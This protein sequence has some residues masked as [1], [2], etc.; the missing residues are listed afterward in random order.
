M[1]RLE[2]LTRMLE[3][4]PDDVFVNFGL[5]MEQR[6]AGDVDAALA[7]FDR[8]IALDPH[9]LAAYQRKGET[10]MQA[11]RYDEAR[12]ALERGAEVARS[13]GEAHMLENINE[14]LEQLP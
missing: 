6:A 2:Q 12:A 8:T 3:K 5:A 4:D 11:G 9:Y 7:Q 1:S 14:M 10:L 13:A